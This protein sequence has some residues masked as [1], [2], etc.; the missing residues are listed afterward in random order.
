MSGDQGGSADLV[1]LVDVLKTRVRELGLDID[2]GP[3]PKG[4]VDAVLYPDRLLG[5]D[6]EAPIP[7]AAASDP[8]LSPVTR[9]SPAPKPAWKNRKILTEEEREEREVAEAANK[10]NGWLQK[11]GCSCEDR[12]CLEQFDEAV[13]RR[14]MV[15]F[16]K[17]KE[18]LRLRR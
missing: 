7:G 15:K 4:A 14:H 16:R 11:H 5:R 10:V 18:H 3:P 12:D 9:P 1:S 8:I 2:D 17:M 6:A 13:L